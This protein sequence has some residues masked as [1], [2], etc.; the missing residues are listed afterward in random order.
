[1]LQETHGFSK[2]TSPIYYREIKSRIIFYML[3]LKIWG[4]FWTL[5]SHLYFLFHSWLLLINNSWL[6]LDTQMQMVLMVLRCG[7]KYLEY[8]LWMQQE[9]KLTIL[10]YWRSNIVQ[11][12]NDQIK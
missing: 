10:N 1:M 2:I 7:K 8:T 4:Q 11:S 5:P 3:L 6:A 9:Q 12:Q